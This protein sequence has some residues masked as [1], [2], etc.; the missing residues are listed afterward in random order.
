MVELW[1]LYQ[2]GEI[3]KAARLQLRINRARQ[4][5]HI[6]SSTNAACYAVLH[7]RGIDAGVPKKPIL[8]VLEEKRSA[9]IA[10]FKEEGFL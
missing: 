10:A 7:E 5:L 9:M 3:E 2:A 4:I 8:P 6:P 1:E